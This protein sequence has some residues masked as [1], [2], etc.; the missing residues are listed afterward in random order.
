MV[1]MPNDLE[2]DL[3]YSIDREMYDDFVASTFDDENRGEYECIAEF[4]NYV[5]KE[6]K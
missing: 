6:S 1:I 5:K 2:Y 3:Q 4:L